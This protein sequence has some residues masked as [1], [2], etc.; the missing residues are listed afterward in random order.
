MKHWRTVWRRGTKLSSF[1]QFYFV[2]RLLFPKSRRGPPGKTSARRQ[3]SAPDLLFK[4]MVKE[5]V[6]HI[7]VRSRSQVDLS[8]TSASNETRPSFATASS[9][10]S[11]GFTRH[12]VVWQL[13]SLKFGT[14]TFLIG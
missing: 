14:H 2:S 9:V 11:I 1:M 4:E 10:V 3:R 12:D 8:A 6:R 5:T 7:H 13:A